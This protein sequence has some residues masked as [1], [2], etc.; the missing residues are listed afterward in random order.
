MKTDISVLFVKIGTEKLLIS[1]Y[2]FLRKIA[3]GKSLKLISDR[4]DNRQFLET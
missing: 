3:G 1:I 2:K 4:K